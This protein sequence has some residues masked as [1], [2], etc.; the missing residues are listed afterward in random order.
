MAKDKKTVV[1]K[2][3]S[4]DVSPEMV[5]VFSNR[6]GDIICAGGIVIKYEAITLVPVTIAEWLIKTFPKNIKK[7]N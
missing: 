3:E 5:R 4:S 2:I 1:K 6:S 7:V